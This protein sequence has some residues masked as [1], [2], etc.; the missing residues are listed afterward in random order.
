MASS[1]LL[2]D[3][4]SIK[5]FQSQLILNSSVINSK[6]RD[7]SALTWSWR[8]RTDN[9]TSDERRLN[10]AH[11]L[12]VMGILG[13]IY[14]LQI[15]PVND[16]VLILSLLLVH[17]I[18]QSCELSGTYRVYW[19][20]TCWRTHYGRHSIL[21]WHSWSEFIENFYRKSRILTHL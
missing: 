12:R 19:R 11:I 2:A 18:L 10:S 9:R 8:T 5:M 14:I 17:L 20:R 4:C 21:H 6:K 16:L 7:E 1:V 3:Q 13:D 15:L